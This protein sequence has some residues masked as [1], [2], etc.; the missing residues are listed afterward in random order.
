M[1]ESDEQATATPLSESRKKKRAVQLSIAGRSTQRELDREHRDFLQA[2]F[3]LV[4]M[5]RDLMRI[6][7]RSVFAFLVFGSALLDV[8]RSRLVVFCTASAVLGLLWYFEDRR[9]T[10]QLTSLEVTIL[11]NMSIRR[12]EE[13]DEYIRRRYLEGHVPFAK[14]LTI[15]P[16]L[17]IAS[18]LTCA[19]VR[20]LSWI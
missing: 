9:R 16:L 3:R 15:E 14:V 4:F 12:G 6:A 10:G 13:L 20:Y 17:W 5:A 18:M 7:G 11:T 8:T 19:L 1:A 2:Q